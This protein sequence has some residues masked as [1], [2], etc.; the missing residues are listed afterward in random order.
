MCNQKNTRM[1]LSYFLAQLFGLS[2]A[3][4]AAIMFMRPG[5][6]R[7][8]ITEVGQNKLLT[9]FVSIAGI[10]GGLAVI[11]THNVWV[12]GWPVIIT[13]FGWSALLKS[14]T[15]MLAP[16]MITDMANMVYGSASRTRLVLVIAFALGLYLTGAGFGMV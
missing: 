4:F 8:M 3:I 7:P 13:L 15:Y 2:L 1:E 10:M 6:M 16:D 14:I 12:M 11:L 9:A 5:M